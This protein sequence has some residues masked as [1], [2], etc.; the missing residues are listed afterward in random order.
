MSDSIFYYSYICNDGDII[1]VSLCG[2][3]SLSLLLLVIIMVHNK[4][5]RKGIKGWCL[6]NH[7]ASKVDK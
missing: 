1:E 3:H 6:S 4:Q 5:V 7:A 2:S